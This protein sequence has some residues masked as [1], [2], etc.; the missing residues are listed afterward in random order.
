MP[1]IAESIGSQNQLNS[2]LEAGIA[3]ISQN[4][5]IVFTK[6]VRLV[7]PLDGFV[8]WV[9]SDLVSDSALANAC[10]PNSVLP[11]Q[12]Q[13]IIKPAATINAQGSLHY[14]TDQQQREDE[15]ID[16]NR[17]IFTSTQDIDGFNEI[18][19]S[20]IYLGSFQGLRFSFNRRENLY[21]QAGIYHYIGEAIYPAMESQIIDSILDFDKFNI[22]T[23]NSLPIWLGLNKFM[24]V[25]P[26]FLVP[27]N[28]QPP[29]AS[30]HILPESTKALQSAPS[31]DGNL[32]HYQLV[33]ETVK[34][35]IYGLR[36]FNAL[37]FQDYIFQYSLDTDIMGIM[38]MPVMRDEKRTQSELSVIGMKK[39]FEL[40]ISYYQT[41]VNNLA[42]QLILS[43]IPNYIILT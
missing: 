30:A 40:E 37:D 23:S 11:D 16:I 26:S 20:V 33:S 38:N 3:T 36:N 19:Q 28:L 9:R 39:S 5:S 24:P 41:R 34:L 14:S 35:T 10:Q 2:T 25:Y 31:F 17:V 13:H 29:Y 22:V 21:Q 15:T 4:Q 7:L 12:S 18:G 32:S 27:S 1:S 43:A 6:Y 8:F 42:R